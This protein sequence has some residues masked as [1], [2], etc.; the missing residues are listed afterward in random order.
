MDSLTIFDSAL[1]FAIFLLQGP[2][3]SLVKLGITEVII[4]PFAMRQTQKALD[5]LKDLSP[6]ILG[7]SFD[8]LDRNL[9]ESASNI[10]NFLSEPE[11]Y[12]RSEIIPQIENEVAELYPHEASA[13]VDYLVSNWR[14]D[15]FLSKVL[16]K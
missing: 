5:S 12:V 14:Q 1:L 9:P 11:S 15:A 4:K 7:Q 8:I 16:P 2:I 13:L 3:L 6:K 10:L